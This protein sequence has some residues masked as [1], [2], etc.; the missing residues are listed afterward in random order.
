MT[1]RPGS[2]AAARL[3]SPRPS[4]SPTSSSSSREAGSPARASSVTVAPVM[5][6]GRPSAAASRSWATGELAAGK[7]PCLAAQG[8]SGGVLFPASAVAALAPVAAGHHDLVAK[9]SGDA[10][11]AA[12]HPAVHHH[13]PADSGAQRDA[14]QPVLPLAGAEAPFRP[15]RRIGV[16]G[17]EHRTAKEPLQVLAERLVAPGQVRAEEN[18]SACQVHPSGGADAHRPDAVAPAQFLHEFDDDLLNRPRIRSRGGPSRLA[19]D[20]A[21]GVDDA[22]GDL[23]SPDVDPNGQSLAAEAEVLADPGAVQLSGA[24]VAGRRRQA[25]VFVRGPA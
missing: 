7:D 24:G 6:S 10:E 15:G 8:V 12:F 23:G 20:P 4:H 21:F 9:L 19:E 1:K 3:A 25:A 22:C 14:Y 11:A 5:A 18:R 17:Q 13:G 2:R 16:V